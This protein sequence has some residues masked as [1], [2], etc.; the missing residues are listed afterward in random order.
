M[1]DLV[2]TGRTNLGA[3]EVVVRAV[4]FFSSAKWRPTGQSGR[5]A[6]FQGMPQIP[7]GLMLLTFLAFLC[8]VVP[9]II[10]YF[11]LIQKLRRFQNLVITANPV[12]GGCEVVINY[13]DFAGAA[14]SQF[15][16]TLPSPEA[17]T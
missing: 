13:P 4:Q 12:A 14:V 7:W 6:T 17:A 5:T 8:F 9:G 1:S 16:Q 3:E 10:C 11:L 15:M 2:V